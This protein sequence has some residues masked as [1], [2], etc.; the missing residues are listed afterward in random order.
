M[1]ALYT[2]ALCELKKLLPLYIIKKR[3]Y[4]LFQNDPVPSQGHGLENEAWVILQTAPGPSWPGGFVQFTTYT[5]VHSSP[6]LICLL[7]YIV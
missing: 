4:P 3:K 7:C 1:L 5:A 2:A 6:G